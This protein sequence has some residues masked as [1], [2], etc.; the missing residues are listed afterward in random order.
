[1]SAATRSRTPDRLCADAAELAEQVAREAAHPQP[2]GPHIG[3]VAEG[4][5]V[6][7]HV[8]E[9]AAPG[10]RGWQWHVT[11]ARAARARYVTVDEVT[12]APGKGA[13]LAPDW[14]PWSER[15]RPGDLGPGDLLPT[16]DDDLRLEPGIFDEETPP[17][18]SV[19]RPEEPAGDAPPP[20]ARAGIA[21]VADA[22]GLGRP[23]VL[24]RYGLREAA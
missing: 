19:I 20:P 14:V 21:A 4:D 11:V 15:L 22:L 17:P 7:T 24:S 10:Y 6:V 3:M 2:V 8:F 13:L 5:R 16:E 1:M 18:N 12:L 23:R 9:S